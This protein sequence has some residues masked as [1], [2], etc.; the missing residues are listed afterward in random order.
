MYS[1]WRNLALEKLE[2][3]K[4]KNKLGGIG[5]DHIINIFSYDQDSI[6]DIATL[7]MNHNLI[8]KDSIVF[9]TFHIINHYINNTPLDQK[10]LITIMN[11]SS[12]GGLRMPLRFLS[13]LERYEDANDLLDKME[14]VGMKMNVSAN[15]TVASFQNAERIYLEALIK[16]TNSYINLF[17]FNPITNKL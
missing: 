3:C 5:L 2:E 17:E 13:R 14:A 16:R 10:H 9:A 11:K 7:L 15:R 12:V 4:E 6:D 1:H 8:E